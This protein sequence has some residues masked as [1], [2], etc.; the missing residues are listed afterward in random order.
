MN[1]SRYI[2][3]I[4]IFDYGLGFF[5]IVMIYLVAFAYKSKKELDDDNYQLY[6]YALS[7]KIF[8]GLGFMFLTVYYWG[9]GD[10]YSYFNTGRDFLS[11]IME[12]HYR[13]QPDPHA[14]IF[15]HYWF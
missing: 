13:T 9:G 2:P 1:P 11:H 10:T 12:D 14:S 6:L 4:T 7:V 15:A 5:Y 3:D 8:G